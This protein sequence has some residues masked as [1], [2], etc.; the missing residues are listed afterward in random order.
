MVQNLYK[1]IDLSIL[2]KTRQYLCLKFFNSLGQNIIQWT[3]FFNTPNLYTTYITSYI[4]SK[5]IFTYSS[6]TETPKNVTYISE[7][8]TFLY[9]RKLKLTASLNLSSYQMINLHRQNVR[10]GGGVS[11]FIHKLIDFKDRK[12]L[13]IS[14]NDSETLSI[15]ITNKARNMVLSSVYGPLDSSLRE[16]KNRLKPIFDNI[17]RSIKDLYLVVDFNINLLE[18]ENN[19]KVTSFINFASQNSIVPLINKP[20]RVTK[21]NATA[22]DLILTAVFLNKQ[23]ETGIIKTE[24]LGHFRILL[25][26]DPITSSETKNKRTKFFKRTIN[27][28]TKEKFSE[29]FSKAKLGLY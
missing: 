19:V 6:V 7:S 23:I 13:I 18:C 2:T 14:K 26:T 25:I 28:A 9:F 16:F 12:D 20:T 15:E 4:F 3:K 5:E 10:A 1:Y 29:H 8:R 24:I 22:I 27:T 17:R 21:T 11:L